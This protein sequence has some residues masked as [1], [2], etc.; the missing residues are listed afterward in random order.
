MLRATE[1]SAGYEWTD[2]GLSQIVEDTFLRV[3][4]RT[5][6][7]LEPWQNFR[8][9]HLRALCIEFFASKYLH[10]TFPHFMG[11]PIRHSTTTIRNCRNLCHV[12]LDPIVQYRI[13][14]SDKLQPHH[15]GDVDVIADRD[16]MQAERVQCTYNVTASVEIATTLHIDC[17]SK[18][19]LVKGSTPLTRPTQLHSEHLMHFGLKP[20]PQ[21][22]GF[23]T[24]HSKTHLHDLFEKSCAIPH[25]DRRG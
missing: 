4:A 14:N 11:G 3:A 25:V 8:K 7:C 15:I 2:N 1:P 6:G 9:V 21:I 22:K 19:L 10:E 17:P 12:L 24:G 23:W 20:T 13:A 16:R 18:S 5:I